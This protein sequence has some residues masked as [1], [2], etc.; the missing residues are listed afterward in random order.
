MSSSKPLFFSA[1]FMVLLPLCVTAE[2]I[3]SPAELPDS[4]KLKTSYDVT[5]MFSEEIAKELASG[6]KKLAQWADELVGS[7]PQTPNDVWVAFRVCYRAEN[8]PGACRMLPYLFK[9]AETLPE[10]VYKRD[11]FCERIFNTFR[12]AT[13]AD[14]DVI[15]AACEMFAGIYC[16]SKQVDWNLN[17]WPEWDAE[18]RTEWLYARFQD[19]LMAGRAET[20]RRGSKTPVPVS[21]AAKDWFNLYLEMLPSTDRLHAEWDRLLQ[22]AKQD[23]TN[24]EKQSLFL[25]ALEWLPRWTKEGP[26]ELPDLAWLLPNLSATD[27]RYAAMRL[28]QSKGHADLF[29]PFLQRAAAAPLADDEFKTWRGPFYK[30]NPAIP[31]ERMQALFHVEVMAV[32]AGDLRRLGRDAELKQVVDRQQALMN[33]YRIYQ[34]KMSA[35][36][37]DYRLLPPGETEE[38]LQKKRP[39]TP[40]DV[41]DP[42]YWYY[43]ALS[44]RDETDV[45]A[46]Q[47]TLRAGLALYETPTPTSRLLSHDYQNLYS[48]LVRSLKTHDQRDEL[49]ALF[50]RQHELMKGNQGILPLIYRESV[51]AMVAMGEADARMIFEK[52]VADLCATADTD[53]FNIMI[54]E[55][56]FKKLVDLKDQRYGKILTKIGCSDEHRLQRY[57]FYPAMNDRG[58]TMDRTKMTLNEDALALAVEYAKNQPKDYYRL[59]ILG[60]VLNRHE[61]WQRAMPL[62][63]E[64]M[65]RDPGN[66]RVKSEAL[67][68][69]LN[70]G[71]WRRAEQIAVGWF[72]TSD[73]FGKMTEAEY[74]QSLKRILA[75]AQAGGTTDDVARIQKRID[76]LGKPD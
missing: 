66:G 64:A 50:A 47:E 54:M 27:A 25:L 69:A 6:R 52:L 49:L 4:L 1:V 30:E 2:E 41:N 63:E 56:G 46:Q 68:A 55:P 45:A 72:L 57:L 76:D 23:P 24:L 39:E 32:L 37:D 58:N 18:A 8:H 62:L 29:I 44:Y 75:M 61:Q 10:N 13:A 71:D 5:L 22:D 26:K 74:R 38:S 7:T 21:G 14:A 16:P 35:K 43:K 33:Q 11:G 12:D 73:A 3:P 60:Q 19:A 9:M 31:K 48:V 42:R 40:V 70:L 17:R 67:K 51:P 15:R 53:M 65:K 36:S 28:R 34:L 20:Q 59:Y